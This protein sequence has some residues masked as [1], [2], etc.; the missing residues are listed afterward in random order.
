MLLFACE[1]NQAQCKI[2]ATTLSVKERTNY[3]IIF[4][5][6]KL[7]TCTE[8]VEENRVPYVYSEFGEGVTTVKQNFY[9]H[10][11]DPVGSAPEIG[12]KYQ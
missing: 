6:Y 10:K 3:V 5:L 11:F 8:M 7:F 4:I 2:S 1:K 12:G 9:F